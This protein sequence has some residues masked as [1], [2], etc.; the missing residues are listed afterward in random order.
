MFN[1]SLQDNERELLGCIFKEEQIMDRVMSDLE[2][3]DFKYESNA[4]LYK[5]LIVLHL[6]TQHLDIPTVAKYYETN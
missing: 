1:K 2:P 3:T 4:T 6:K 5:A